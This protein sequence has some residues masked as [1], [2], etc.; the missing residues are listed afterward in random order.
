V[1]FLVFAAVYISH[2]ADK[3]VYHD[4]ID[5]SLEMKL[6]VLAFV[7]EE[8]SLL[9]YNSDFLRKPIQR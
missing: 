8:L 7:A 3:L 5:A 6:Q 2:N 1:R 9:D 4:V